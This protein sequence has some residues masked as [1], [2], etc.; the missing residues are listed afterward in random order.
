MHENGDDCIAIL[1]HCLE[2]YGLLH[3]HTHTPQCVAVMTTYI[4][5]YVHKSICFNPLRFLCA[6]MNVL[7]P[8]T[9]PTEVIVND[10]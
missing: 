4:H 6:V 7:I 8:D 5:V 9:F 10:R 3:T 1:L 2:N